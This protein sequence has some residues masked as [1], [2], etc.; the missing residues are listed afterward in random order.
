MLDG[1]PD[2]DLRAEGLGAP[3]AEADVGPSRHP[4]DGYEYHAE[5]C[6]YVD[7]QDRAGPS[8]AHFLLWAN[9]CL[10]LPWANVFPLPPIIMF[11]LDSRAIDLSQE[12]ADLRDQDDTC[13]G[14]ERTTT[15]PAAKKHPKAPRK[16]AQP[17][18]Q[19][20]SVCYKR[21]GGR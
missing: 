13:F 15:M 1:A 12:C 19:V 2:A 6:V 18:P 8:L 11:A 4:P 7:K 16:R 20:A 3:H 21:F 9:G 17:A 10:R 5:R 14:F